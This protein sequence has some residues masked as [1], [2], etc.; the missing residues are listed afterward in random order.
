MRAIVERFRAESEFPGAVA[1]VWLADDSSIVVAVGEADRASHARMEE[2]ALLHAGSIGKTFFAALILQLVGEG[3]IG[4]DEKVSRHLGSE[5]WYAAIPNGERLTV[6]MLLNH[7]SGLAGWGPEF[8]TSL[9]H[10]PGRRR[11]P[12]EAVRSIAGREALFAPGTRFGYS[13]VNYQ[14]LQLIAERVTGR[15]AYAEILRRLLRPLHL[16]QVVPATRKKISGLVQGYAGEDSFLGLDA[17]MKNGKLILDPSFEGGGGGFVTN[18][19]DLARWMPLFMQGKAFPPSLLGE[20]RRGIPAGQL[21]VGEDARSGL[22]VEIVQTPLGAAYGHG[23]F[24]PGYLS[25]VLWYPDAGIAVAIQVNSSA[26][27]ALSRPLREVVQEI[28]QALAPGT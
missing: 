13:D 20:V 19:R 24:F 27:H 21:D 17:V 26:G 3:R 5:P 2:R 25:L 18:A 28:A 6:R 22:G 1:A 10:D 4:L 12:V 9:V 15:S 8:M 11:Q 23:G 14:L 16:T 7:S